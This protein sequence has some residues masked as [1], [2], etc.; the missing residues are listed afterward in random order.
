MGIAA[1]LSMAGEMLGR[2][3]YTCLVH[4]LNISLA[5]GGYDFRVFAERAHPDNR[6][7]NIRIHIQY[8][9]PVHRDAQRVELAAD[10]FTLEIGGLSIQA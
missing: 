8:W 7:V 10:D 1:D 9:R 3:R 4:P 6:I 2:Y 5:E